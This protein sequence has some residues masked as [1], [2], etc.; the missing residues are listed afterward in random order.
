MCNSVKDSGRC[1]RPCWEAVAEEG[2]GCSQCIACPGARL[3]S[4]CLCLLLPQLGCL[5]PLPPGQVP[6]TCEQAASAESHL[7][8]G[9]LVAISPCLPR[10][11]SRDAF[12]GACCHVLPPGLRPQEVSCPSLP[13]V[14]AAAL[15]F[16]STH[17]SAA[18]KVSG[19]AKAGSSGMLGEGRERHLS[20]PLP[21]TLSHCHRSP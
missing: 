3:P 15:S 12:M 8:A 9:L 6:D 7:E 19:E 4:P 1:P 11:R 10:D 13:A 20:P 14:T 16:S 17:V 5:P 2:A 18:I 21:Q